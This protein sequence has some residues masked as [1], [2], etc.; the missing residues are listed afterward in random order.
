MSKASNPPAEQVQQYGSW[1]EAKPMYL[2]IGQTRGDAYKERMNRSENKDLFDVGKVG[3]DIHGEIE[4]LRK[5][6]M[7]SAELGTETGGR[8]GE[9][10][11]TKSNSNLDEDYD[12]DFEVEVGGK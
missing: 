7:E 12:A 1:L 11:G 9:N 8:V 3:I 6:T 2:R 5:N 4:R 10:P